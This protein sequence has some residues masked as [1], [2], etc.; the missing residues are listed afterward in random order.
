MSPVDDVVQ[1]VS[2]CGFVVAL[3]DLAQS[4]V[5]DDQ[6]IGSRPRLEA[7]WIRTVGESGVQVIEQVDTASVAHADALLARAQGKRFEDVTL[8]SAALARNHQV[9]VSA[10]EV[11]QRKL[12]HEGFV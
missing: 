4:D 9:F 8:A 7:A 3:F 5:V 12:E 2:S 6:Q 10:H 1:R 11:E